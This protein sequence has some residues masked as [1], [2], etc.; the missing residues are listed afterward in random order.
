MASAYR[1]A[2]IGWSANESVAH[3]PLLDCAHTHA[4]TG[5]LPKT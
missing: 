2:A 5:P 4:P 3:A 1:A